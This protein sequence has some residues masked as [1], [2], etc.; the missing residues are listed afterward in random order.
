MT[1]II[2]LPK[3]KVGQCLSC[4]YFWSEVKYQK[5]DHD[6]NIETTDFCYDWKDIENPNE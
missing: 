1:K 4:C 6:N 5:C 2:P 3:R